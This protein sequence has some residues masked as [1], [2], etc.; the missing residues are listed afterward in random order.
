[1]VR[2]AGE[3][4]LKAG[5]PMEDVVARTVEAIP[6]KVVI[7]D[8]FEWAKVAADPGYEPPTCD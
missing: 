1:M 5:A 6:N 3:P 8:R 4:H 7:D 2:L